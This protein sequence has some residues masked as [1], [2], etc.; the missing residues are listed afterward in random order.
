L[1][2]NPSRSRGG[3]NIKYKILIIPG[4]IIGLSCLFLVSYRTLIA[5]FSESNAVTIH[6]NNYGEQYLDIITLVIF[7]IICLVGL[8]LLLKILKKEDVDKNI[9]S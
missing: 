7:W 5:F 4:Y 1:L 6:V 2:Y 3:N 9:K 8:I